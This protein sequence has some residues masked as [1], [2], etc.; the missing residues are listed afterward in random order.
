MFHSRRKE[1][2]FLVSFDDLEPIVGEIISRTE[3]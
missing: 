1:T 3:I 2:E